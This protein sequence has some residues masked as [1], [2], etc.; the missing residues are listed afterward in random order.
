MT[1]LTLGP[2][3]T[4]SHRAAQAVADG[5]TTSSSSSR[6]PPSSSRS[7]TATPTAGRRRGEQ[8]RGVGDGVAGR[9]RR[10]R[11]RGGPGDH[12]PDSPRPCWPRATRSRRWPATPRR[13]PSAG[14]SSN[15]TTP[16][17]TSRRWWPRPPA[18]SSAH[19][20]TP[21]SPPSVTRPTRRTPRNSR[22][23]P[24]TSRTSPPTRRGSSSS[25]PPRNGPTRGRSRRSSSTRR[26]LPRPAAGTAGTVRRPGRQLHPRRVPPQRRAPGRLRLPMDVAAGLYEERTQ[27]A[28]ADIGTSPRRAGFDGSARTTPRRYC[29]EPTG[30][31]RPLRSVAALMIDLF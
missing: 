10:I 8:H 28:L 6:S 20:T 23:W 5:G 18:A 9:L 22:C 15:R 13:W 11:R 16:T 2:V 14:A 17:P 3:G 1:T 12:H 4:Y 26:R 19:A 31:S 24:R 27:Q 21:P 29:T 7:P 30:A 25:P